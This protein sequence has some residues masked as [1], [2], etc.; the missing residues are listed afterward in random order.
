MGRRG[1]AETGRKIPISP[2]P[3]LPLSPHPVP[4]QP[5]NIGRLV[6]SH[7]TSPAFLQRAAIVAVVSFLFFLAMLVAFY[8]RQQI[9]YF[10]L[11]TG[12]LV[13]YV[14]TLIG[15]VMQKRNVVSVH[16]HGVKYKKFEA[17]WDEIRSV[18]T[19]SDGLQLAKNEREKVVIPTSV[20]GYERIVNAVRKGVGN[21]SIAAAE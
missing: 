21:P 17:A 18:T 11:S 2:S 8:I 12:F 9:G 16:E 20:S 3:I 5:K 14:F 7:S 13:V 10:L 6:S 15:W 4:N 1:E 19:N